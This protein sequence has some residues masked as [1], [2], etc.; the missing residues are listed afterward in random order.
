M[1]LCPLFAVVFFSSLDLFLPRIASFALTIQPTTMARDGPWA[2]WPPPE[3][4]EHQGR[5]KR[6]MRGKKGR[7][8]IQG[9]RRG[10]GRPRGGGDCSRSGMRS[11]SGST[12]ASTAIPLGPSPYSSIAFSSPSYILLSALCMI[13]YRARDAKGGTLA[14]LRSR[15]YGH[16]EKKDGIGRSAPSFLYCWARL[17]VILLNAQWAFDKMSLWPSVPVFLLVLPW[18]GW[19]LQY[20]SVFHKDA[21]YDLSSISHGDCLHLLWTFFSLYI[22]FKDCRSKRILS[23]DHQYFPPE[24]Y[25]S[26]AYIIDNTERTTFFSL[27]VL[28]VLKDR[29]TV[30]KDLVLVNI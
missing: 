24:P 18:T 3:E 9:E 23:M 17:L 8:F 14:K 11:G 12:T 22:L 30:F 15:P 16:S 7:T 4:Q 21:G 2:T 5:T 19:C 26:Q 13:W 25:Y 28:L 6:R 1:S 29:R 10:R 20:A 27:P